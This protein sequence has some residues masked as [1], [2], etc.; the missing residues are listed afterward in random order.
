M[1]ALERPSAISDEH[2]A[3]ARG[4]LVERAVVA[5]AEELRDDLGVERGAAGGDALHRVDELAHVGDAVLEQV[6]DAAA[7]VGQQLLA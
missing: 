3:L 6:A 1:A 2:L 4:E 7:A 5:A